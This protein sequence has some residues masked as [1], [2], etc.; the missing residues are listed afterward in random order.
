[1]HRS[2]LFGIA[3][4]LLAANSSQAAILA[5]EPF[6]SGG[7]QYTPDGQLVGQGPTVTG[8]GST[9][10]GAG[11]TFTTNPNAPWTAATVPAAAN[12]RSEPSQ[13][14]Y[15]QGLSQ[16]V[17]NG[18]QARLFNDTG[19]AATLNARRN[20]SIGGTNPNGQPGSLGSPLYI[21]M[22]VQASPGATNYGVQSA[23][24]G[25]ISSTETREFSFGVNA[26]GFPYVTGAYSSGSPT[27]TTGSTAVTSGE[28]QLWVLKVVD[29]TSPA[30]RDQLHFFINPSLEAEPGTATVSIQGVNSNA[31][32]DRSSWR[33]R[34]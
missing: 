29:I 12:T 14:V 1:M 24:Q 26:G 9:T 22:L 2:L 20:L 16:L 28:P 27:T 15:Q 34:R 7:S 25:R 19:S 10:T 3:L 21:S 33:V 32:V 23:F 18:G 5:Y 13:L 17:T 11:P 4:T 30:N 6:I 8:F 31:F